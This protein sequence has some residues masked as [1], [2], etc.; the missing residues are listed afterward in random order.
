MSLTR[1]VEANHM[2]YVFAFIAA[3]LVLPI[4]ALAES[5]TWY[6]I[7]SQKGGIGTLIS[8]PMTSEEQCEENGRKINQSKAA[9]H[10]LGN[11]HVQYICIKGK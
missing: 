5:E 7:L 4:G 8:V 1:L 9:P 6:L 2:K 3:S 11:K 10:N